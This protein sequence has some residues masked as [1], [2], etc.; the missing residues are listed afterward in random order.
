MNCSGGCAPLIFTRRFPSLMM[1]KGTPVTPREY[2]ESY[3]SSSESWAAGA[4]RTSRVYVGSKPAASAA[5]RST[6]RSQ[7]AFSSQKYARKMFS[8]K[9]FCLSRLSLSA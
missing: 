5:A 6:S 2:L 9:T 3:S 4:S 8:M 7:G 1:K